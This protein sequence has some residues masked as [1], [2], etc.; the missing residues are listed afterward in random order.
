[1]ANS[2]SPA[3]VRQAPPDPPI[4][5]LTG[6]TYR[7][8]GSYY[9]AQAEWAAHLAAVVWT[10]IATAERNGREPLAFL[11]EYLTAY[12]QVLSASLDEDP[13][14]ACVIGGEDVPGHGG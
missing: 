9:G 10:I 3:R 12:T 4:W 13:G 7:S 8:A 2:A 6:R 14:A 1:M 5:T 11:T